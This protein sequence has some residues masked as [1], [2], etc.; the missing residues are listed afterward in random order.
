MHAPKDK[1][2]I[3]WRCTVPIRDPQ[4]WAAPPGDFIRPRRLAPDPFNHEANGVGTR[5]RLETKLLFDDFESAPFD[6]FTGL[7]QG[8]PLSVILYQFYN[9]PLLD[10]A[11]AKLGE[12]ITGNIDDVAVL[13]TGDTFDDTHAKL[14]A[15][16]TRPDGAFIWSQL[17]TSEFSVEKFGLLNCARSLKD[18]G[19]SLDL[20]QGNAPIAASKSYKFLGV[21][22]DHK[23]FWKE[24]TDRA[25]NKGLQWV[26][27]FRR[28]AGGRSGVGFK[29]LRQ[30]YL[31]KAVPAM[32]YAADVFLVPI[33]NIEGKTHR[34]GSV[35]S[36]DRLARVHKQAA[37]MMLGAYR[38]T[39]TD[40]CLAHAD[41]LP[42]PLLV[43]KH[44]HRALVRLCSLPPSHPLFPLILRAVRR[45]VKR[46][47][48]TLHQLLYL[49]NLDPQTVETVRPA[50]FPP[51]WASGMTFEIADS[52]EAAVAA[53]AAWEALGGVRVYSDGSDF[54]D[55][56]GAAAVLFRGRA[57]STKSLRIHLGPSSQHTVYE[58][59]LAGVLLGL[60]MIRKEPGLVSKASIALDNKAAVLALRSRRS[61]PGH[62][63]LDAVHQLEQAV[64]T[65]HPGIKTTIRWVPGH[66]GVDGNELADEEAKKAAQN[67]SSPSQSL[68]TYLRN[69]SL[70]TSVSKLRQLHAADIAKRAAEQWRQSKRHERTKI[71]DTTP[72]LCHFG[73]YIEKLPRRHASLIFQLRSGRSPLR[74]SLHQTGCADSPLCPMCEEEDETVVHYFFKCP[75]YA[76]ARAALHYDCGPLASSLGALLNNPRLQSAVFAYIHATGRFT[77]RLGILK[78]TK[79]TNT[80]SSKR[81]TRR[82][83]RRDPQAAPP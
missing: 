42:F 51:E 54:R 44:C 81:T 61:T 5:I 3:S 64:K 19:P 24:Q 30:L 12:L 46:H 67:D 33:H 11:E 71:F 27:L 35:G 49:F 52:K 43:E 4:D 25:L 83:A 38:N 75:A 58:S 20:G 72:K 63:L 78:Y 13:A 57:P 70:P 26:T 21:L 82:R 7:D 68:P 36:V 53:D 34:Q 40:V 73:R 74:H 45:P 56:V 31:S 8:C 50:R 39:A 37:T 23:L 6:I 32:L 2:S 16:M 62:H 17:H 47:R 65:R 79:R 10:S 55:G 48:S 41:L 76:R 28:M 9:S 77:Q 14:R 22:V 15:F 59:E 66:L 60:H 29:Q 18:L 69:S 80:A 1:I